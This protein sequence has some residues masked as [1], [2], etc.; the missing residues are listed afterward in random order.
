MSRTTVVIALGGWLACDASTAGS[1]QTDASADVAAACPPQQPSGPCS[2]S[3]SC[4]YG[5][6][7]C[8]SCQCSSGVWFCALPQCLTACPGTAPNEGDPCVSAGGCC[9]GIS[10]GD[11]CAFRCDAGAGS[12]TCEVA[13]DAS[14]AA[15]HLNGPCPAPP[16]GGVDAAPE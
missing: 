5:N 7:G 13:P 15:W 2:G 8:T 3:P 4:N 1:P 10:V 11:T 9:A 16:D 14:E 6:D 12:A